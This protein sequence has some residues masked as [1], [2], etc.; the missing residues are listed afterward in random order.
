VVANAPERLACDCR[1]ELERAEDANARRKQ[2]FAAR[3][4]A[5][6]RGLFVELDFEAPS[7]ERN[8]E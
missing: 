4:V 7:P 3:F 1:L 5:W 8:G 6:E 2:A